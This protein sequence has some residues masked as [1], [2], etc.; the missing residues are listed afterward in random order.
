MTAH[1][2]PAEPETEADPAAQDTQYYRR[3]LHELI[4]IGADL[5]RLVHQQAKA[6]AEADPA[7]SPPSQVPDLTIAFDRTARAVRRT[8]TLARRLS[9][10]LAPAAPPAD[11]AR[12]T[13]RKRILRTVEDVIQ[14]TVRG[15]A[16]EALNEELLERL[17][18]PD[19]DDDIAHRPTA[20]IIAEICRDLGVAETLGAP[21]YKRRRPADIA[22]LLARATKPPAPRPQTGSRRDPPAAQGGT[23]TWLATSRFRGSG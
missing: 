7:A 15:E 16:A 19:L 8:I 4:D 1:P 12:I 14:R 21:C 9:E 10:P 6:T 22:T 20:E 23:A 18:S 11:H 17:D 3:V 2:T 13:A 5:A